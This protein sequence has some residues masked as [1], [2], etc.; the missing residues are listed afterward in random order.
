MNP[1]ELAI[2]LHGLLP[3][4]ELPPTPNGIAHF[5]FLAAVDILQGRFFLLVIQGDQGIIVAVV[6]SNGAEAVSIWK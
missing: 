5:N 3:S 1:N 4:S 2:D 6:E